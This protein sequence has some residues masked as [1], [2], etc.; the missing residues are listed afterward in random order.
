MI[1][2]KLL[3]IWALIYYYIGLLIV[4]FIFYEC[5]NKL[6]QCGKMNGDNCKNKYGNNIKIYENYFYFERILLV[7]YVLHGF[8]QFNLL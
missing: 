4:L 3:F 1:N 2:Q 5:K 7:N 8:Y 6:R